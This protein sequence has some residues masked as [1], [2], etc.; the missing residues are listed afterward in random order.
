MATRI[1]VTLEGLS[2]L[3]E[4]IDRR[5]LEGEDWVV[6]GALVSARIARTVARQA[7]LKAKAARQAAQEKARQS[8]AGPVNGLGHSP[9]AEDTAATGESGESTF[10]GEEASGRGEPA[11]AD[12][13]EQDP[14]KKGH[15]RNGAGA[16]LNA[17]K[18]VHALADGILGAICALCGVGRVFRYRDKVI[19]RVVGQPIFAAVRHHFEQ[20]RCR[21]CG[22]IFTAE[23]GEQVLRGGVGTS[24]ILYDWSACAMLGG[25][26]AGGVAAPGSHG[27]RRDSLPSPGSSHQPVSTSEP[28]ASG[29]TDRAL[30]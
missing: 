15:G 8:E 23:G 29:R 24:Y 10:P 12:S 7:R 5:Q 17:T 2:Q 25:R 28:I 18:S 11:C 21:L 26:V 20:G 13:T 22:A 30:G 14:P 19:L 6:I 27:S 9:E 16:F 3:Q 1:D 4:R